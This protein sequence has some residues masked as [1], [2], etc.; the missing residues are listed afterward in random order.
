MVPALCRFF[1]TPYNDVSVPGCFYLGP[2][3]NEGTA[4]R[5]IAM[6]AAGDKAERYLSAQTYQP[7][8]LRSGH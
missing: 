8:Q 7:V 1:L 3:S 2:V 5:E 4:R 6:L